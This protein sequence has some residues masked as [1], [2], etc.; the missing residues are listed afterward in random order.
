MNNNYQQDETT[1]KKIMRNNITTTDQATH[2]RL[3]IYYR[4]FKTSNLIV[5]NSPTR[6]VAICQ[7]NVVYEFKCPIGACRSIT[8]AKYIGHT[9]NLLSR[10]LTLHLADGSASAIQKHLSTHKNLSQSKYREILV[11]NTNILNVSTCFRRL[12]II[13][14][15]QIKMINPAFN[16]INFNSGNIVLKL[17]NN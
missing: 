15:L 3:I 11:Q 6:P 8:D 16:R 13:E 1:I 9:R 5:K 7:P 2:L 14:A 4:K 12:E 17:F 10:R